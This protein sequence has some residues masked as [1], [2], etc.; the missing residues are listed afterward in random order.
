MKTE[1]IK[2]FVVTDPNEMKVR[3]GGCHCGAVRYEANMSLQ[4]TVSC[5][6]S[7]CTKA[8][9]LLA[10]VPA[11]QFKLLSGEEVLRDYQF[12]KKIAHHVFCST[13]G[14]HSFSHGMSP[15]GKDMRAIN[16]RC[17]DEIDLDALTPQK[18]D[19]RSW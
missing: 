5:N 13:C 9:Y 17:L 3:T 1:E 8:G 6:C 11:N 18:I 19:G 12:N 2:E 16:L 14:I 7:I 15:D 4:Y 10:F